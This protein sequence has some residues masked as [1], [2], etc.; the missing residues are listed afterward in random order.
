ML[1]RVILVQ[2]GAGAGQCGIWRRSVCP[3]A[4]VRFKGEVLRH[5]KHIESR[6]VAPVSRIKSNLRHSPHPPAPFVLPTCTRH[7]T[8]LLHCRRLPA[9][10]SV[11]P[12]RSP[13]VS[14]CSLIPYLS[15]LWANHDAS[16]LI[17]PKNIS[18]VLSS[19]SGMTSGL[20]VGIQ[21]CH[22]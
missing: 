20:T 12:R 11:I 2:G 21:P 10:L 18:T 19:V 22:R 3:T 4:Q 16:K 9:P 13:S 17:R 14:P 15:P 5:Q 6:F 8:D 1:F 7:C